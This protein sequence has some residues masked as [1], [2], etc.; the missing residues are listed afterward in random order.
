MNKKPI[1]Q[2]H[3]PLL[4]EVI[5][6]LKRAGKRARKEAEETGTCLIVSDGEKILRIHPKRASRSKQS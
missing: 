5:H 2:A 4:K 1:E 6:A 3:D